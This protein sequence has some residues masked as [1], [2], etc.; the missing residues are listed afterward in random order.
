MKLSTAIILICCPALVLCALPPGYQDKLLC[1]CNFCRARKKMPFGWVGAQA[2]FVQCKN[3]CGDVQPV[4]TWGWRVNTAKEL[5]DLQNRGYH[6]NDCSTSSAETFA[7]KNKKAEPCKPKSCTLWNDG[8][9]NCLINDG[10]LG[11][12]TDMACL[13]LGQPYCSHFK[14]GMQCTGPNK[15]QAPKDCVS[16]F[17]GCNICVSRQGGLHTCT[18]KYCAD[19]QQP[20]CQAYADGRKC[21]AL[22]QCSSEAVVK[23]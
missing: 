18:R 2:S 14:D 21:E 1:P 6:E 8:C 15:C 10:A 4:T 22:D 7:C 19:L 3:S 13:T 20:Y 5:N 11:R 23:G 12:C 17:D 9:N 16:F